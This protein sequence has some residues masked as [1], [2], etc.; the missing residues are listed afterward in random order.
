MELGNVVGIKGSWREEN[1]GWCIWSRHIV[2]MYKILKE[3]KDKFLKTVITNNIGPRIWLINWMYLSSNVSIIQLLSIIKTGNWGNVKNLWVGWIHTAIAN[4]EAERKVSL[5]ST[6]SLANSLIKIKHNDLSVHRNKLSR[7][8]TKGQSIHQQCVLTRH[9]WAVGECRLTSSG[10]LPLC[11]PP[12]PYDWN[13][14]FF[15]LDWIM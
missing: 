1:E 12:S 7:W 13:T 8:P 11:L 5:L 3:K 6:F 10:C 9:K 4:W 15:F 2:H 14:N